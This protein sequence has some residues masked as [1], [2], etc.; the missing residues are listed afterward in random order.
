MGKNLN[1][2]VLKKK[3]KHTKMSSTLLVIREM[4]IKTTRQYHLTPV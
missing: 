3:D 1:R 4:Q 2:Y